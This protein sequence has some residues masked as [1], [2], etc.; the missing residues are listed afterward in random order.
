MPSQSNIYA[1]RVNDACQLIGIGRS[2]LYKLIGKGK[3]KSIT[4]AGRTLIPRTEIEAL[5]SGASEDA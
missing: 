4:I 3:L 1:Y 2:S 5:V